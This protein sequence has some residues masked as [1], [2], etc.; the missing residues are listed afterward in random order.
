[1]QEQ[2]AEYTGDLSSA[3]RTALWEHYY[4]KDDELKAVPKRRLRRV[5]KKEIIVRTLK[6]QKDHEGVLS[7]QEISNIT[8]MSSHDISGHLTHL[9]NEGKVVRRGRGLFALSDPAEGEDHRS[10]IGKL[11]KSVAARDSDD[12]PAQNP[13]EQRVVLP[14]MKSAESNKMVMEFL[15][16]AL[17]SCSDVELT[18]KC[19]KDPQG[20]GNRTI[21]ELKA[22]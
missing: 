6:D 16:D 4:M 18:I 22:R 10:Q 12:P 19:T 17:G 15:S 13:V 20:K 14:K 1:L 8:G 5:T 11:V 21:I 7:L 9:V 3:S 2:K